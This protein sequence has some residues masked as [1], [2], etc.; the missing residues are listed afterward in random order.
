MGDEHSRE[1]KIRET[2][3]NKHRLERKRP[4]RNRD[5]T[6][7]LAEQGMALCFDAK[8]STETVI[9]LQMHRKKNA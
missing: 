7:I 2:G 9:T 6:E 3:C 1:N 8:N 5:G 4:S